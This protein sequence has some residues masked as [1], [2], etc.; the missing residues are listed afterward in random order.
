MTA[1]PSLFGTIERYAGDP[2]LTLNIEFQ[3][4]P[5]PKKVNLGIGVYTDESGTLPVLESVRAASER[6]AFGPR[7]YLP[8]EGDARY[9]EGSRTLMFGADHAAVT[10]NRIATVQ[11]VGGTS[12]IALAADF[13][14]NQM[15]DRAVYVSDPTWDNHIQLFE[16]AGFTVK[17]YP[18]LQDDRRSLAFDAMSA[19]LSEAPKGSIVLFQPT[20][21]NPSGVDLSS[22][23]F[24]ALSAVL[25]DREHV[26]VFD[27]A[28][29]GFGTSLDADAEFIRHFAAAGECVVAQSFSKNFSLYGERVGALHIVGADA[30]QADRALGQLKLAIRKVYSNPPSAGSKLVAEVLNDPALFAQWDG[31]VGAMRIRMSSLREQFVGA[32]SAVDPK[33][34]A[35]FAVQQRG[36]FSF[37]GIVPED[38]ERL[39]VEHGI[40]LIRSGRMCVAGLRASNLEYVAEH[41]AP[42]LPLVD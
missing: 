8:M 10:S 25:R 18:Y 37:T 33:R 27:I 35:S 31:E 15:P 20:C 14:F 21:H 22:A 41:V 16:K 9:R 3:N 38:V 26:V 12:A 29:Q 4:D 6:L 13:L 42:C 30:D 28:Y 2:I 17:K 11:T 32:I 40:Y 34:D 7:P 5:N 1:T 23:Q 19:A 36:M 24:D 39:R